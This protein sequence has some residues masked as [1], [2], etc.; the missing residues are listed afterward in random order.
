VQG[1]GGMK[2]EPG[3]KI[4][5]LLTNEEGQV[6][7]IM[8]E[9]MVMIEV[10][11]V[12]FP[13]YMD[14]IDFPYF[15]MFTE[16]KAA[17]KQKIFVDDIR[18]EKTT[19][20]VKTGDGVSLT[21]FPVFD[22]DIFEDDIVEKFKLYLINQNT[23]A[24]TFDYNCMIAGQSDFQ[25]KNIIEPLSD[26][27]LH[28]VKFEDLSD[29]PRFDFEF[30]LKVPDKKKAPYFETSLKLKAK[31]LFKKIEEIRLKN[32][33]GFTYP[34]FQ[35]YP[36]KIDEEKVDTSR[37][38]NAG[39]RIYNADHILQ[40]LEPARSVVDLHIEKLTD[41]RASLTNFEILTLQLKA[42]DKFYE[43]AVAHYQPTL[44]VIHG[45]GA[46]KLRDAIHESLR[47]KKEVR[48]FVNQYNHLFGYGATEIYFEYLTRK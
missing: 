20:K 40:N 37:L 36:D 2:Y 34:L 31:Q 42:F 10:K 44:T 27:Y 47:S 3:D 28:D 6:V 45:I 11:G 13:V 4:I 38:G 14:Q 26:F 48:S 32:Q 46:G 9:K 21:F 24:Y 23:T 8:N 22:K 25:L 1:D 12:R 41:G 17:A 19:A 33:P 39:F 18:K 35:G 5:V 16:K 30:A 15:K 29:N 43:L 7:E